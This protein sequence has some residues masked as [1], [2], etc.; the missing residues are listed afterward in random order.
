MKNQI[1]D[2]E[3]LIKED[4]HAL[5]EWILRCPF[6]SNRGRWLRDYIGTRYLK[7]LEQDLASQ[8]RSEYAYAD[9]P[10]EFLA[11]TLKQ[12]DEEG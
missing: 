5:R 6:S 2:T 11:M 10:T 7:G 3:Q 12:M 8:Y 4:L 1:P 9:V